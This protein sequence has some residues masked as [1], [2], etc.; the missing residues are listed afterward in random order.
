MRHYHAM[1]GL[2][3]EFRVP[4]IISENISGLV[5]SYFKT[6][7]SRRDIALQ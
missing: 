1:K 7:T 2:H 6:M 3:E 5:I 4:Q